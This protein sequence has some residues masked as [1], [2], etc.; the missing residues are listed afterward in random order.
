MF[1]MAGDRKKL[2]QLCLS[3]VLLIGSNWIAKAKSFAK[4]AIF[5]AILNIIPTYELYCQDS[6]IYIIADAVRSVQKK[7]YVI[8]VKPKLSFS[9]DQLS[10]YEAN[11][12]LEDEQFRSH[13]LR[14]SKEDLYRIEKFR[15]R[16]NKNNWKDNLFDSS[17]CLTEDSLFRII[18]NP[19]QGW[20]YF[21]NNLGSR[22][23]EFSKPVFLSNNTF[24]VFRLIYM[25]DSSSGYDLLFVYK[26]INNKW[27]KWILRHIGA[28]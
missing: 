2:I 12:L 20:N 23:F 18:H 10:F 17:I 14:L 4:K 8:Y 27:E 19:K 22:F 25:I 11:P 3:L 26:K 16:A 7:G 9:K 5:I 13:K 24:A 21:H 15:Y 28:W 1:K 6:T